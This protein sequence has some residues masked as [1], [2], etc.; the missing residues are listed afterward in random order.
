LQ[1]LISYNHAIKYHRIHQAADS[2][3]ILLQGCL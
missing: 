2:D 3:G 1:P